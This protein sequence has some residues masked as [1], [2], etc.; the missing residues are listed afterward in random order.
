MYSNS[1]ASSYQ[2]FYDGSINNITAHQ[3]KGS[4]HWELNLV[5]F[6]IGNDT[7]RSKEYE[8]RPSTNRA[9]TD[10]GTTFVLVPYADFYR[11]VNTMCKY[12]E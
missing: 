6:K 8:F 2:M 10:T 9:F 4:F 1:E 12:L 11:F 7:S 3:I 5:N